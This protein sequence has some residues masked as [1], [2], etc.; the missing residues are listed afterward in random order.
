MLRFNLAPVELWRG[1]PLGVGRFTL[2]LRPRRRL[3]L[4]MNFTVHRG[5][6]S[7]GRFMWMRFT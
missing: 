3:Y 2:V 5:V 1:R 4:Y 6:I 7:K